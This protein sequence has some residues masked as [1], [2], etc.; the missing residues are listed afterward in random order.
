MRLEGVD[1]HDGNGD[2]LPRKRSRVDAAQNLSNHGQAV[3][4]IAV[5]DRLQVKRR[6]VR[7]T[8]HQGHGQPRRRAISKLTNVEIATRT[9]SGFSPDVFDL[10]HVTHHPS[11]NT[12]PTLYTHQHDPHKGPIDRPIN[13]IVNGLRRD[14]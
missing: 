3:Q 5:A 2:N 10:Q 11:S 4:L 12:K 7:R 9:L 8:V 13:L 6:P 14:E 1:I